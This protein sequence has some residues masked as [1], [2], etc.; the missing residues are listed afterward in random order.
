MLL[1]RQE[2]DINITLEQWFSRLWVETSFYESVHRD[3][4]VVDVKFSN[5]APV[6]NDGV[7]RV[8]RREITF[9]KAFNGSDF[10]KRV[11][12]LGKSMTVICKEKQTAVWTGERVI[13]IICETS[14][15][16][17]SWAHQL[18]V[19]GKWCATNLGGRGVNV[20]VSWE[21]EYLGGVI[22]AKGIL[23]K[24]M[25]RD[26]ERFCKRYFE[27]ATEYLKIT[28]PLR[29]SQVAIAP[30][31]HGSL[32]DD[33]YSGIEESAER[34]STDA[35]S[36]K[37]DPYDNR[38]EDSM[39]QIAENLERL[40]FGEEIIKCPASTSKEFSMALEP[41]VK[42]FCGV[43]QDSA[44]TK[45]GFAMDRVYSGSNSSQNYGAI[46]M[47]TSIMHTMSSTIFEDLPS[48]ATEHENTTSFSVISEG[49]SV[50]SLSAENSPAT[51]PKQRLRSL[52][53]VEESQRTE[54]V[55]VLVEEEEPHSSKTSYVIYRIEV[56][57]RTNTWAVHRRFSELWEAHRVWNTVR[58][59]PLPP[60]P[61]K[62]IFGQSG[63]E[64]IRRRVA[65]LNKYF[66][67]I[68]SDERPSAY[69]PTGIIIHVIGLDDIHEAVSKNDVDLTLCILCHGGSRL[70]SNRKNSLGETPLH[71]CAMQGRVDLIEILLKYD[72]DL[73]I[74]D[75][76]D[77]TP[78][79][80]AVSSGQ[81]AAVRGLVCHGADVEIPD[82]N[83]N[84]PLQIAVY[85]RNL[86]ICRI[87]LEKG[88]QVNWKNG[89]HESIIF[90]AI[91]ELAT[92]FQTKDSDVTDPVSMNR[93]HEE[94]QSQ[95]EIITLLLE[96]RIDVRDV[97]FDHPMVLLESVT[98]SHPVLYDRW[99][100]DCVKIELNMRYMCFGGEV[101][102]FVSEFHALLANQSINDDVTERQVPANEKVTEGMFAEQ[103]AQ[104]RQNTNR[105]ISAELDR[106]TLKMTD[107]FESVSK[108]IKNQA[109]VESAIDIASKPGRTPSGDG[110][111]DEACF[112]PSGGSLFLD[113]KVATIKL[114]GKGTPYMVV[115]FSEL[116]IY[117]YKLNKD[118]AQ[119]EQIHVVCGL[120]QPMI[121]FDFLWSEA[122]IVGII[123]SALYTLHL[124][125]GILKWTSKIG[126][127]AT[128]I[129]AH[130]AIGNAV[131][132]G[133]QA[134]VIQLIS[135][136]NGQVVQ[137]LEIG[138]KPTSI[139][140]DTTGT[141]MYVGDWKGVVY[142]IAQ[143]PQNGKWK[144]RSRS[145]ISKGYPVVS[146]DFVSSFP[147]MGI[148][149]PILLSHTADNR[150]RIFNIMS[151]PM[152]MLQTMA[153]Y[154][155]VC[156]RCYPS[157]SEHLVVQSRLCVVPSMTGGKCSFLCMQ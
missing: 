27:R 134:A 58:G 115:T 101:R 150:V 20:S 112:I 66:Q 80:Y 36:N 13:M 7:E 86:E 61:Q 139:C 136:D 113:L 9:K 42:Q 105:F 49:A 121:D 29:Q 142:H 77:C 56:R 114:S 135:L 41:Q 19:E 145:T 43:S 75:R 155:V 98:K 33:V 35:E 117:V 146:L 46:C 120:E 62:Q 95:V 144:I 152:S 153:D 32:N 45:T 50:S 51:T 151:K 28:E 24:Q 96:K 55:S 81:D 31:V 131:V 99:I 37:T 64:F 16:N 38:S 60:F 70:V 68:L 54:I 2:Q 133:G 106:F 84:T 53:T 129:K 23:E 111:V 6:K 25:F 30:S 12:G 40:N 119:P 14:V 157:I 148:K 47:E 11:V 90:V 109:L 48:S 82:A 143:P 10:I 92:L 76:V 104:R 156:N 67:E 102:H 71:I 18:R 103:V 130:P 52:V 97:L 59:L 149:T 15:C 83:G 4:G 126:T 123:G 110:T 107:L 26:S 127:P 5:W 17:L 125:T 85:Q 108:R 88:A 21:V 122:S 3:M 100:K 154:T 116:M 72:A 39:S 118:D 8:S 147:S 137:K 74:R 1:Y 22:G 89:F 57:T 87:L 91:R 132:V 94:I 44:T 78:L 34:N 141:V 63:P 128:L 124:E 138:S 69:T 79:V 93:V 73:D 140:F 65:E